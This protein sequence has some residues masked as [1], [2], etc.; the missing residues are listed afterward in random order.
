V[1]VCVCD[2]NVVNAHKTLVNKYINRYVQISLNHN[3]PWYTAAGGD[4]T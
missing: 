2:V 1:C 3:I 4:I